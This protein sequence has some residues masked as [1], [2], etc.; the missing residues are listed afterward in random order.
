MVT[1]V[2]GW[3]A[4]DLV[5]SIH[6]IIKICEAFKEAGGATSRYE[7]NMAFLEGFKATLSKLDAHRRR[8]PSSENA[9]EIAQQLKKIDV[10][11]CRFEKFMLDFQPA[12][13]PT[14]TYSSI[15]KAPRKVKWAVKELS[16]VSSK[17]AE[18]K[19]EICDP[20]IL[21]ESLL[22]LQSLYVSGLAE[23]RPLL[24]E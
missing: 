2:F 17:V 23:L 7:E 24:M 18:L 12:L 13:G 19:K 14:S 9:A 16:T 5:N 10:P 20:L 4:G 1:P 3:S 6:I 21:I 8:N 11:Y 15:R 22:Q